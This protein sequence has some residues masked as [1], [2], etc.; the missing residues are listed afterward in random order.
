M[1]NKLIRL[2]TLLTVL[3]LLL[4]AFAACANDGD[5]TETQAP[6]GTSA[7][8]ETGTEAGAA[9]TDPEAESGTETD[10]EADTDG[11]S[12][13]DTDEDTEEDTDDETED[14]AELMGPHAD[15]IS[16]AN[17]L[18]NGVQSYFTD[19]SRTHF[20]IKNQEM[21][22][23]YAR[24]ASSAQLVESLE[25]TQ[26]AAYIT[27]TMD[28]FIR[29]KNP[30]TGE[31][32]TFYSSTSSY[33][34]EV[35][36]YRFGYYYY[37]GLFEFQNFVPANVE[38]T[39][40]EDLNIKYFNNEAS[41]NIKGKKD[42]SDIG[43]WITDSSDPYIVYNGFSYDTTEYNA[44]SITVRSEGGATGGMLRVNVGKS[45][46]E[47]QV[48]NLSFKDDGEF[49]TYILPLSAISGYTDGNLTGIRFDIDGAK[50]GA[51]LVFKEMKLL[52]ADY[53]SIPIDIS[54]NRHFHVYSDKMHHAIQYAAT[55]DT[56]NV[57]AIGM[58]TEI[59]ADTVDKMI[60]VDTD[61]KT[62]DNLDGIDWS[63]IVA[64]GFDIKDAG[65][66]G[67]I[68]PDAIEGGSISVELSD[69]IYRIV[70][71]RAPEG[72]KILVSP[73]KT[74][75]KNDVYLAQ[76]V[77]TDEN[78][79][80]DEF[81]FETYCERNPLVGKNIKVSSTYSNN[82]KF[83]GYD[84]IR[85]IY[86]LNIDSPKGSFSE[87]YNNPN[88]D[89]KINF[90]ISSGDTDRDIYI[91]TA[92]LVGVLECAALLDEN[93]MHL[94]M[95][96][97]V[98]K[99]FSEPE[100]ERNLFNLDDPTF[101][102]AIWHMSLKAGEIN[103]YTI[104]N[105]YQ[106]WGRYPLKQISS[107][108]FHCPYYH[109]STGT[110]ETNC[111]VPWF[112]T[113]G[114][115]KTLGTLPD[116]RTMSAPLWKGQPQ[117]NSCGSHTWLQYT[118]SEG[119]YYATENIHNHI[120]SY[121]PTYAEL[122]MTN[123]S[124]DGKILIEYSHMEM[125]QVDENRTYYTMNYTVLEDLTI[126]D[127][128]N[129][130]K[131]YS[132]SDNESRGIYRDI[133][134]LDE[135]NE[136]AYAKVCQFS[137]DKKTS[138][139]FVLGDECP[140]FSL[141]NMSGAY[142]PKYNPTGYANTSAEG[143]ANL[144]FLVYNSE[145]NISSL[146]ETPSFIITETNNRVSVSLDL[147]TVTLK[148]GDTI[149]IN[150][151]LL[152]WGSQELDNL[153]TLLSV[154]ESG[155]PIY[156]TEPSSREDGYV[157]PT[158]DTPV[159]DE[160]GLYL[161]KNARNVREDTLLSPL[162]VT[163][164]T[165]E[166]IE[167]VYVPRIKSADGKTAEF[168]LSGGNNNVAARIYGFDTLGV[169]I[170]EEF[171]D[172]K[173]VV[174]ELSS[175]DSPN[176]G[177]FPHEYDGYGVHY[178]GDG[179]YSYSFVTTMFDGAPRK[180]RISLDEDFDSFAK[181]EAPASNL[182][183]LAGYSDPEELAES[184]T[185]QVMFNGTVISEDRD[186]VT[187]TLQ[188]NSEYSES[189]AIV[190]S[191]K[192]ASKE[193]GQYLA[194]KYRLPATNAEKINT[195]EIFASTLN[196][197]ATGGDQFSV[198][199][200]PNGEWQVIIIDLSKAAPAFSANDDGKYYAKY[201][202]LDINGKYT[203][204]PKI[205]LAF[206]GLDP[207]LEAICELVGEDFSVVNYVDGEGSHK[208]NTSTASIIELTYLDPSSGYTQ[209]DVAFASQID[210]IHGNK[211][212]R[213]SHS[214]QGGMIRSVPEINLN[215]N[216]VLKLNGWC[217]ADGGINKY[218]WSMD[219]GKTWQD[220]LNLDKLT[221]A[222]EDILKSAQVRSK[223]TFA[224]LTASA[225][226]AAFQNSDYGLCIDLSAYKDQ[227]LNIVFA[228]VPEKDTSTIILLYSFAYLRCVPPTDS[229][230]STPTPG[231]GA[232]DTD[233]TQKLDENATLKQSTLLYGGNSDAIGKV[234]SVNSVTRASQGVTVDAAK[235]GIALDD[236]N[237]LSIRGW[238][239]VDGG[240]SK[241][242][243]SPDNGITWYDVISSTAFDLTSAE[244]PI[245]TTAQGRSG[246]KF[247]DPEGS[248]KNANFQ[249][250]PGIVL[251]LSVLEGTTDSAN[252]WVAAVPVQDESTVCLLFNITGLALK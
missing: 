35:N 2:L 73:E 19:A 27:N 25:N 193:S 245:F 178:D 138:Q 196:T 231:A 170:V 208:L 60:L 45:Y 162:T 250:S 199:A 84:P 70:Q 215:E 190:Y 105:L 20:V 212:L 233:I 38:Y 101:S 29:M 218:I 69:G 246:G 81:L 185:S 217:A 113:A 186:Y 157:S 103:E 104:V 93:M 171:V 135:N 42:G 13:A 219:G 85:G 180:F 52:S 140:Y 46:N 159:D 156:K 201:V 125:P 112:G 129:N 96:I 249:T 132:V 10:S 63:K 111:I 58:L 8:T 188:N 77:Y 87:C 161:D 195:F 26:G 158:Y 106:N 204:S 18:A 202:R 55:A 243:W 66:F 51:G 65:I 98:I 116:F 90:D 94:P 165:D 131:F 153:G 50:V 148:A 189:Y 89:W 179:T 232:T 43:F 61:G 114:L 207:S 16:S 40:E 11:D 6:T 145:F 3:S 23:T 150:A 14:E 53:S 76:R 154:S 221:D 39:K 68:L 220:V 240:I 147:D 206:V 56:E 213:P 242:V 48:I 133:G 222:N 41:H 210:N 33:S 97:E 15:L 22:M 144:A 225:K 47:E 224:D 9:D 110:T 126:N 44:L 230:S 141:F 95:P 216:Y 167:S 115:A 107:I 176:A 37:Q 164:E 78:H 203:Q 120:D 166:I 4:G 227:T 173:W 1:K 194:I 30:S 49:H 134:Y 241:F 121:G 160:V 198:P 71:E 12:E 237:K 139:S 175:K 117:H 67:F 122:L 143:Y 62:Y 100:G 57:D 214:S 244:D 187:V 136:Y 142:D 5:D 118:D 92:A 91:M 200:N 72:N 7:P 239:C 229:G 205:D 182:D 184:F 251:D 86:V 28:A 64:V 247:A 172:G 149:T 80:F 82:G 155:E 137:E 36:L 235:N 127:F 197:G 75:N 124:D 234:A 102:E 88:K 226:N 24:S 123:I 32:N 74:Q 99:N 54:T 59:A 83:A 163:S 177:E 151:I 21:K 174:Y 34:A 128:R 248:F 191:T 168:T 209:S 169:P 108:P 119:N 211:G 236:E 183:L 192:D 109:L 79:S 152:P 31:L 146:D 130:F 238:C 252:I 223:T 17:A 181:E 228:A